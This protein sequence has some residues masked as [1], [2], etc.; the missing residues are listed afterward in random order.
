VQQK[1]FRCQRRS[2]GLNDGQWNMDKSGRKDV[3]R[4]CLHSLRLQR[5][6]PAA[7]HAEID[8]EL[9]F[10]KRG[11]IGGKTKTPS[12]VVETFARESSGLALAHLLK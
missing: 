3:Y 4:P 1:Q 9:L 8:C 10:A 2:A 11:R 6:V 5:R 12:M 7:S